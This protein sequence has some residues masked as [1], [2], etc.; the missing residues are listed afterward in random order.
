MSVCFQDE[1]FYFNN[2]GSLQS[3]SDKYAYGCF[4]YRLLR[5]GNLSKNWV[6]SLI[7]N[8]SDLVG[9]ECAGLRHRSKWA[10]TQW[11]S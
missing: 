1:K 11:Y 4:Q 9:I 6:G 5:S 7:L 2:K 8:F 3:S 10:W